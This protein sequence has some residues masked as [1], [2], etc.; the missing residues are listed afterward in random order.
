[1]NKISDIRGRFIGSRETLDYFISPLV[2]EQEGRNLPPYEQAVLVL[3]DILKI[4]D[5][6]GQHKQWRRIERRVLG[7]KMMTQTRILVEDVVNCMKLLCPAY[8]LVF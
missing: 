6:F 8:R 2:L 4:C 3:D 1:M 5:S 7:Q